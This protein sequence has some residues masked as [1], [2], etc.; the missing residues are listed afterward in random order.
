MAKLS[1]EVA[2][3]IGAEIRNTRIRRGFVT[4]AAFLK[5]AGLNLTQEGLR[6]IE[7]G[8][9]VPKLENLRRIGEVLR[10]SP[11]RLKELETLALA[12]KVERVT[13]K[14]GNVTATVR[15]DGKP[16]RVESL[17]TQRK[18]EEFARKTTEEIM[19]L[20]ERLGW[21]KIPEDRDWFRRHTRQTILT[22]IKSDIKE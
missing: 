17:P 5:E 15:I 18:T 21:F 12:F 3:N 2:K 7:A 6:K 20:A 11:R 10:I 1:E 8:E 9:R 22:N 13:R 16:L 14:A 19:A 4:R